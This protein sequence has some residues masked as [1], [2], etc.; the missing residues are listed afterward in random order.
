MIPF[1]L[2]TDGADQNALEIAYLRGADLV[3]NR[4]PD[5]QDA[6]SALTKTLRALAG[7]WHREENLRQE[8]G[9]LEMVLNASPMAVCVI[10]GHIIVWTNRTFHSMLGYLPGELIGRDPV[11]FIAGEK[12]HR[13]VDNG[14]FGTRDEFGWGS[15]ETEVRRKDGSLLSCHIQSRFI[16]PEDPHRGHI[17]VGRDMTEYRRMQ[18]LLRRSELRY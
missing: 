3:L 11:E 1:V 6:W 13:R 7:R 2:V 18:N 5:S 16:D 14:L 9:I 10:R 4:L 17:V 8:N 15:I 12:E